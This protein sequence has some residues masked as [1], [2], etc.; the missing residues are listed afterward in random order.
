MQS[1]YGY[2]QQPAQFQ[3]DYQQQLPLS[4]DVWNNDLAQDF[5]DTVNRDL[6]KARNTSITVGEPSKTMHEG[7]RLLG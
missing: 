5:L 6:A 4:P 7:S 1:Q 2:Q 3:N